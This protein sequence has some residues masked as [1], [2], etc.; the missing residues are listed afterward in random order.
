MKLI[1]ILGMMF[2]KFGFV[3]ADST[4]PKPILNI[5]FKSHRDVGADMLKVPNTPFFELSANYNGVRNYFQLHLTDTGM[6]SVSISRRNRW[7]SSM[8]FNPDKDIIN[9]IDVGK[10]GEMW[11]VLSDRPADLRK[12]RSGEYALLTTENFAKQY[13]LSYRRFK[14]RGFQKIFEN[15]PVNTPLR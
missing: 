10:L 3:F 4:K 2:C 7:F 12:F 15:V 11:L 9:T 13:P 14:R 5:L 1:I 6:L 8:E